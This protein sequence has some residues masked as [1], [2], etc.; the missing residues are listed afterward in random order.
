MCASASTACAPVTTTTSPTEL[1]A[2]ASRT[3][4]RNTRCFGE[5]YR[6]AAPAASTTAATRLRLDGDVVDDDVT[7]RLLGGRVAELADPVDDV[8]PAGHLA[9]DCVIGGQRSVL[10]GDDEEL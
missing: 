4:G 5:P 9:D 3:V 6:V 10:T 7:R 8:D 1:A 2:S